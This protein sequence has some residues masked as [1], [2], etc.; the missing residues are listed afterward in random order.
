MCSPQPSTAREL[1]ANNQQGALCIHGWSTG[2]QPIY[3]NNVHIATWNNV[4][5]A[6]VSAKDQ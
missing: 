1:F 5:V 6:T 2:Q 4:H 3:W